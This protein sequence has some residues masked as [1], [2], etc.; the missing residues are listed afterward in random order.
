MPA[1]VHFLKKKRDGRYRSW[2]RAMQVSRYPP[3]HWQLS[4]KQAAA[5]QQNKQVT[6]PQFTGDASSMSTAVHIRCKTLFLFIFV[7]ATPAYTQTGT[8]A[9]TAG[10]QVRD[11]NGQGL[12]SQSA[13]QTAHIL[14]LDET[15]QKLRALQFAR[16]SDALASAEER[17]L[18]LELLEAIELAILDIDGAMAEIGNE[19]DELGNIRTTLQSRRD[20]TVSLLTTAALLTGSGLGTAVNAMQFTSLSNQTQNVGDGIG[21]GSGAA[22]TILS[23]LA[24]RK[25]RG[26]NGSVGEVSNML[27]PLLGGTPVLNTRYPPAVLQFLQSVPAGE[28]ASRGTRLDQLKQQWMRS[29]R[30]LTAGSKKEQQTVTALTASQRPDVKVSIDDLTNRMA[31]LNDVLGRVSLMKRDLAVLMSS[32]TKGSKK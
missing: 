31:M 27:A 8:E 18:R 5:F 9:G 14:G 6:I 12:M 32:Y 17:S 21:I 20:K 4:T 28:D 22:S 15:M 19:R 30:L 13:Q 16:A 11:A 2:V 26:P 10:L 29:G 24:A 7:L 23:I 25:Q 3:M 1:F